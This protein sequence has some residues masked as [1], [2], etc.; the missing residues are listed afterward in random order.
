MFSKMTQLTLR[1]SG[2]NNLKST[3][4]PNVDYFINRLNLNK[5]G[6]KYN[7]K[8][9]KYDAIV[10]ALTKMGYDIK[11][12]ASGHISDINEFI[13]KAKKEQKQE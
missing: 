11:N 3:T 12:G 6:E 8:N 9:E 10:S 7:N 4:V 13:T 5:N 2:S 1:S